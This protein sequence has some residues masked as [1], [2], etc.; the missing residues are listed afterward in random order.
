MRIRNG[1]DLRILFMGDSIT[2]VTPWVK[3]FNAI[4][5]RPFP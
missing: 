2:A 1:D 5:Q 4:L 3:Q